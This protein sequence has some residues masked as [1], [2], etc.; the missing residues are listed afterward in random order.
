MYR[1]FSETDM[2]DMQHVSTVRAQT[3]S[4]IMSYSFVFVPY[5]LCCN[6]STC[7][8]HRALSLMPC[9]GLDFVAGETLDVGTH[10][11]TIPEST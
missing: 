4:S 6:L 10:T 8:R 3:I 1:W 9:S 2:L 5:H 11:S 7:V